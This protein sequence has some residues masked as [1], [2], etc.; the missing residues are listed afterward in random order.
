MPK[1]RCASRRSGWSAAAVG[2]QPVAGSPDR[3]DGLDAERAVDLLAQV[4]DVDVD[5]VRAILVVVVPGVL[6][7]REAVEHL[8][9][10]PHQRLEQRVLLRRQRDVGAVAPDA[11]GRGIEVQ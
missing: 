2:A 3:L 4:T 8:T 6:E 11:P 7:E 10:P 9:G 1:P 5:D